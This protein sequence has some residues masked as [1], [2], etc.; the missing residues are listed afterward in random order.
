MLEAVIEIESAQLRAK[1][2]LL[3]FISR[4]RGAHKEAKAVS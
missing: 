1:E 4:G 3:H 2:A